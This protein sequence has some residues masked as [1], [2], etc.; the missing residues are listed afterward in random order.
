MKKILLPSLIA[1]AVSACNTGSNNNTGD[2]AT[3]S[4]ADTLIHPNG[5]N[6]GDIIS[7]D[8]AAFHSKDTTIANPDSLQ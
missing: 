7:T 2:S 1:I 8:T 3:I 5:V 6:S 4:S